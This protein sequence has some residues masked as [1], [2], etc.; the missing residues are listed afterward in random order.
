MSRSNPAPA[1]RAGWLNWRVLIPWWMVTG[2][3]LL[4]PALALVA[5]WL[6]H[7][8]V[9]LAAM[10]GA[11]FVSDVFDGI[12]ARRWGSAT[13]ALRVADSAADTIFYLGVLGAAAESAWPVLRARIALVVALLALEA[14]R[15]AF[16]WVKFRR[17]ASYHSYASKLWGILLAMAAFALLYFHGGFWLLTLALAWGILCD[18]EGLAMS[19]LLPVWTADV[20]TLR[21]AMELRKAAVMSPDDERMERPVVAGDAGPARKKT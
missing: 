3:G 10:L 5:T 6:P 15:M 8:E 18:V 12:L 7:P 2:R 20:K 21:Q 14:L 4:G 17:M 9:W 13:D 1:D 19:A 11:G 16:D